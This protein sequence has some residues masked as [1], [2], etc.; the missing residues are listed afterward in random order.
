MERDPNILFRRKAPKGLSVSWSTDNSTRPEEPEEPEVSKTPERLLWRSWHAERCHSLLKRASV[1]RRRRSSLGQ[2]AV[3][4]PSLSGTGAS[5]D[6][7]TRL[8]RFVREMKVAIE[9]EDPLV[10]APSPRQAVSLPKDSILPLF[11]DAL[12]PE[13]DHRKTRVQLPSNRGTSLLNGA[14]RDPRTASERNKDGTERNR[15]E[16]KRKGAKRK[17]KPTAPPTVPRGPVR[18]T[19]HP[20]CP[21]GCAH[22]QDDSL[23]E[24]M[25]AA[26]AEIPEEELPEGWR[27]VSIINPSTMQKLRPHGA[28]SA[29]TKAFVVCAGCG[30]RDDQESATYLPSPAPASAEG[31]EGNEAAP[32]PLPICRQCSSWVKQTTCVTNQPNH[33]TNQPANQPTNETIH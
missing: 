31:A 18:L 4:K 8:R 16:T 2:A 12:V 10:S 1:P 21:T 9:I 11:Y 26:E 24:T 33:L 32:A 20:D 15:S 3:V 29:A 6:Q 14:M 17:G 19:A 23:E 25:L 27:G 7:Y 30:T 22:W 5:F 28:G 13:F